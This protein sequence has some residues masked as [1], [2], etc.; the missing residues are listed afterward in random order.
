MK[1]KGPTAKKGS[2]G[3]KK[4]GYPTN[5]QIRLVKTGVCF[6]R[7]IS[8]KLALAAVRSLIN[9]LLAVLTLSTSVAG[10]ATP[11]PTGSP[12][13]TCGEP[14]PEVIEQV[15]ELLNWIEVAGIAIGLGIA[16]VQVVRAGIYYQIGTKQAVDKAQDIL[17]NSAIGVTI[18][19]LASQ[20]V[21]AIA[22]LICSGGT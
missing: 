18:I 21:K 19:L 10:A 12:A 20:L 5:A 8:R 1:N 11:T 14:V 3:S 16:V 17:V 6:S 7:K 15:V 22:R 2:I 9:V 4:R 13:S